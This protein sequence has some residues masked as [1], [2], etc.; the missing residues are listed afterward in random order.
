MTEAAAFDFFNELAL[1]DDAVNNGRWV[2]YR[3]GIEF[4]VAMLSNRAF[5][6]AAAKAYTALGKNLDDMSEEEAADA[7]REISIEVFSRAT[8]LDWRGPVKYKGKNL[9]YSQANAVKL[10]QLEEF[11]EWVERASADR[12]AYRFQEVG[13]DAEKK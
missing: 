13:E 6:L 4:K 10:L 1:D 8:L 2:E 3:P 12:S 7:M 9:K 5:K 11:R